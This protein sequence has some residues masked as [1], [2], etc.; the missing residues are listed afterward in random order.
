MIRRAMIAGVECGRVALES[1]S[2][3]VSQEPL[4]GDWH[5]LKTCLGRAP[6]AEEQ[7]AFVEGWQ[8]VVECPPLGDDDRETAH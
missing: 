1:E 3:Q 4:P 2:C 6:T 7:Q 5:Y 8:R